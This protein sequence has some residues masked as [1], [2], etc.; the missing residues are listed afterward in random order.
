MSPE[1]AALLADLANA[2]PIEAIK[3]AV[4]ERNKGTRLGDKLREIL[5]KGLAAGVAGVWV[6][7]YSAGSISGTDHQERAAT[8][9]DRLYIVLSSLHRLIGRLRRL[10][11]LVL[12]SA[13]HI[14]PSNVDMVGFAPHTP[15]PTLSP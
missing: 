11:T 6:F 1:T 2:D 15:H 14:A 7:S 13:G 4:I 12:V 10:R 9:I 5:G 8:V 3:D